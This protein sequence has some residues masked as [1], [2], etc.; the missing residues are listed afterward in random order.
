MQDL[1]REVDLVPFIGGSQ[2]DIAAALRLAY[3]SVYRLPNG[4]RAAIPNIAILLVAGRVTDRLTETLAEVVEAKL[5][6]IRVFTIGVGSSVNPEELRQIASSPRDV[7]LVRAATELASNVGSALRRACDV[8][9]G[10]NRSICNLFVNV[11]VHQ[12]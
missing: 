6:N 8:K 2:T 12:M 10:K 7:F 3:Q 11:P 4:D 5:K 9:P 1:Q